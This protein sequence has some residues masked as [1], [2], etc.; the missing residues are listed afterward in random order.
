M[1]SA[2]KLNAK[3]LK[4]TWKQWQEQFGHE[5]L[6]PDALRNF[7]DRFIPAVKGAL[8]VYPD[9]NVEIVTGGLMLKKSRPAV[10]KI[11]GSS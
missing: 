8:S 3:G 1:L 4:V 7:K 10:S 2:H 11:I 9:A 6:G 5:Y